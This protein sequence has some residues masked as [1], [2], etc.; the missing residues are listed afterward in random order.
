MK[1]VVRDF[2][3]IALV[4]DEV[5]PE[6]VE[7]CVIKAEASYTHKGELFTIENDSLDIN[8]DDPYD[9]VIV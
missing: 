1:Q 3:I 6:D 9:Y 8:A 5:E 2:T 7:I 4:H